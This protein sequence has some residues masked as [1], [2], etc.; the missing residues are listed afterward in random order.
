MVSL[1]INGQPKSFDRE[2]T[3]AE[4]LRELGITS[5]AVAVEVNRDVVPRR[6]HG[7]RRLREGD[8]VEILTFVGGG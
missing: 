3:I 5:E 6:E 8:E 7:S 4:V 1:R 2:P